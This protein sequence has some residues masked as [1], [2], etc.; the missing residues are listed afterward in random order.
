[1]SEK[2]E[3]LLNVKNLKIS[4][5]TGRKKI[6][7][8]I[9]GVDFKVREAQIIGLVGESGSGKSVSSKSLLNIN[10]GAIVKAEKIQVDDVDILKAYKSKS[11]RNWTKIRGKKIGY[12][13]QDP[14]TSLNPTRKIGDQML[15]AIKKDERFKNK[16]EKIAYCIDLLEKFGIRDAKERFWTYPHSLSGGQKQ[17][18][19]IAMVVSLR[20]K[21][22]IA[23][24][25][26]TALDP[27]VQ[28]AVLA[29]FETIR[30]Q[31]KISIIFISHN[32]SVVAKFCDYIYVMYAGRI[33]ERATK[34]DLFTNPQ[35]PYTWALLQ[36]IPED[37]DVS[38]YNIKGTPPDMANLHVGDPFAPRNEYAMEIDFIK[39]P[40]LFKVSD[41]HYAATWLL[42]PDSPKIEIPEKLKLKLETT[43]EIFNNGNNN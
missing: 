28:A 36:S 15:D 43:K 2:K 18:I 23:D 30:M 40:P 7:N 37:K 1:M 9:R 27:T 31:Y 10:E 25:P 33:V 32:I 35:H 34:Y 16:K 26:T 24:E 39:E 8:I 17:R 3:Y 20:P 42:H 5:K 29:L 21:L 41:S 14:L 12:I 19:V 38:L 4:F 22:I 6:I 11:K 13:P